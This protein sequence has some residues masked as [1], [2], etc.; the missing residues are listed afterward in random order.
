MTTQSQA[1]SVFNFQSTTIRVVADDKGEPLFV[2]SDVCEVLG[3]RNT[4]KA[5]ADHC[6][7]KGITK[8]YTLTEK[9]EQELLYID[10]GNL[11]R[12]IIKSRKPEAEP[13]ESWVCD[14]VLPSIRKTGSYELP[15][16][17]EDLR[18]QIPDII[19][20]LVSQG[21]AAKGT[22]Y[23]RLYRRFDVNSYK[24]I[25]LEQ[26]QKAIDYLKAMAKPTHN[27]A[28]I[29][30]NDG[31]HYLVVKNGVVIW[32]KMLKSHCNDIPKNTIKNP[33]LMLEHI[34][35]VV[36]EFVGKEALPAPKQQDKF[37]ALA[38]D[39]AQFCAPE[40]PHLQITYPTAQRTLSLLSA[41]IVHLENHGFNMAL[42][43]QKTQFVS[44]FL[45]SYYSRLEAIH[46]QMDSISKQMSLDAINYAA[47]ICKHPTV[48]S[49]YGAKI[50]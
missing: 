33:V 29:K 47:D 18:F 26:C 9:G 42:M 48:V 11:Y 24:E 27:Q 16:F 39:L 49:C 50:A 45:T 2:A 36:G 35:E 17:Q 8:R 41:L 40:D 14:E 4:S 38:K 3:Y 5:I 34:R 31:E 19:H 32:E 13:F 37:E 20:E 1:L 10:E 28:A 21:V 43:Y 6:R 46:Y 22:I 25:P 15:K 44:N 23:N 12:L 7:Q 30:I